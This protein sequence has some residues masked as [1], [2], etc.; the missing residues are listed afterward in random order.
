MEDFKM[1]NKKT[2]KQFDLECLRKVD[3]TCFIDTR[4]TRS[5]EK[6]R[7][8]CPFHEEKTASFFIYPNNSYYCFGCGAHGNGAIDFLIKRFNY[9]FKDAC[10]I[11]EAL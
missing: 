1:K 5:S 2:Y 10:N 11:L 9:S 3:F 8:I 6:K 4:I 7:T